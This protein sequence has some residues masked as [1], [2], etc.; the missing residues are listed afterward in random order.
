[1]IRSPGVTTGGT[2]LTQGGV[3]WYTFELTCDVDSDAGFLDIESRLS[4]LSGGTFPDDTFMAL[5]DDQGSLVV[6]DDD[7]G[8]SVFAQLSF[9]DPTPRAGAKGGAPFDGRDGDLPAGRYYLAV[10]GHPP[11]LS[12]LPWGISG[13]AA[14]GTVRIAINTTTP[15]ACSGDM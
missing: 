10:T 7:D 3:V 4:N 6:I 15:L 12:S 14:E 2:T 8:P 1:M 5:Y 11:T 13:N 9:G